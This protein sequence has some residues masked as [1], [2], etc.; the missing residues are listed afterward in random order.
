ME[1]RNI[2]TYL[3]TRSLSPLYGSDKTVLSSLWRMFCLPFQTK[4]KH[5]PLWRQ[6]GRKTLS[7]LYREG[8]CLLS[9]GKRDI[10]LLVIEAK[11]CLP[12]GG[13][14]TLSLLYREGRCLLATGKRHILSPPCRERSAASL[15]NESIPSLSLSKG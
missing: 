5:P 3:R 7:P 13:R 6:S 15:D 2:L 11:F 9:T 4:K 1:T 12:L 10:L 14:E 8:L